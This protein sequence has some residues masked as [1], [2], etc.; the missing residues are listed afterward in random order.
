MDLLIISTVIGGLVAISTI[1]GL[2]LRSREGRL[3][4]S[5]GLSRVDRNELGHGIHFGP[6]ATLLQFSTEFCTKCPATRAYLGGVAEKN[7]GVAHVDVDI[8]NRQDLAQKYN[9]MQTPT[10]FILDDSG[11]IAGRIGGAPRPEAISQ[12]LTIALRRDHD[13]Y[14]I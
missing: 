2:A 9:I 4:R 12:A 14:A 7:V 8:T 6:N 13:S 5:D 11:A 3:R 1:A 10:T